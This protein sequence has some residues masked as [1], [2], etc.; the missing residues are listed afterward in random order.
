MSDD[1]AELGAK[2]NELGATGRAPAA[3]GT[4]VDPDLALEY[5]DEYSVSLEHE[6]ATDT[7]VRVSCV[8]NDL[9]GNS[10]IWN[11]SRWA[12]PLAGGGTR[13]NGPDPVTVPITT[14]DLVVYGVGLNL[15]YQF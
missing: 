6:V 7:S 1:R 12:P 2:L 14:G 4:P 9:S 10:G 15:K 11:M 5:V 3:E 8:R 13:L